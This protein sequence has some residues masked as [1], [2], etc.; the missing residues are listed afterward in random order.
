MK[1]RERIEYK[2]NLELGFQNFV[3]KKPLDAWE[4]FNEMFLRGDP[5]LVGNTPGIHGILTN[6]QF[7]YNVSFFITEQKFDP[8]FD[9]GKHFYYTK[10]KWTSLLSNYI[11]LDMLDVFRDTIREYEKDKVKVRYYTQGFHF[12]DTH[13]NGKGCILSGVFSR[14]LGVEKPIMTIYIRSSEVTTRLPIDLLFFQRMGTYVYGHRDFITNV[15]IKQ[16]YADDGILVLY[17]KHKDLKEVMEGAPQKRRDVMFGMLDK[18][19]N[20]TEEQFANY[21]TSLRVFRV[22][23][24]EGSEKSK[25]KSLL[26]KDCVIGNWEGIPLPKKCPSI[27]ERNR[28]KTIYKKFVKKYNF[29]FGELD[30]SK[31]KKKKILKITNTDDE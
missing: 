12:S 9:F 17:H 6:T 23:K 29:D 28:L 13:N 16:M 14:Q 31:P 15:V 20:G 3:F 19:L 7:A 10:S 21:G 25:D 24:P 27:I 22:L 8:E 30:L 1:K 2:D 18:V 5:R 4:A 26:A 11:D